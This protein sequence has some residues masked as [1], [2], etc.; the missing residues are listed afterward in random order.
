MKIGTTIKCNN[1]EDL[2]WVLKQLG[3]AGYGATVWDSANN[4]I[5]ITSMPEEAKT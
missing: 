3:E 1:E 4:I 5:K 2:K